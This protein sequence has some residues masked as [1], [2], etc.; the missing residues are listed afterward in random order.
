MAEGILQLNKPLTWLGIAGLAVLTAAT[1][2]VAAAQEPT[3]GGLWQKL[4][5]SN[6]PIVWFLF[7][8]RGT[9]IYEGAIAKLFPRPGDEPNPACNQCTGDRANA[10]LLG[11]SFVR[12]MRRNGLKYEDG[13]ILDPRD[14]KVYNAIMTLSPDGQTLT[15]R[16]Y[17]G[18]PLLGMDEIW[19]RLPDSAVSQLDRTV[20]AKYFPGGLNTNGKGRPD[21]PKSKTK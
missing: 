20:I 2:R 5:E 14:G 7:V 16:G 12:G 10:P 18:I 17:L 1:P 15:V 8:D 3:V 11:L 19:H 4:D 21:S 13:N 6:Q 9:S